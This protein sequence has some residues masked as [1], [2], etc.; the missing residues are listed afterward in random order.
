MAT[1]TAQTARTGG[2]TFERVIDRNRDLIAAIIDTTPGT[3]IPAI[4]HT[5]EEFTD[6]VAEAAE[7][8]WQSQTWADDQDEIDAAHRYLRDALATDDPAARTVLLTH[9]DEHLRMVDTDDWLD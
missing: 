5:P 8:L 4:A 1:Q 9:A 3:A 6:L 7:R 2:M